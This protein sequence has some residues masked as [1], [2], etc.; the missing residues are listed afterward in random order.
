MGA[1]TDCERHGQS[2][3]PPCNPWLAVSLRIMT[4]S[5]DKGDPRRRRVIHGML[6]SWERIPTA[7]DTGDP[8][9]RRVIHGLLSR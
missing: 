8:H 1:N 2:P 7:R 9:R 5:G 6:P 4:D 3:S